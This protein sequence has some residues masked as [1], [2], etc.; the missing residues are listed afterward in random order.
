MFVVVFVFVVLLI[1]LGFIIKILIFKE[2]YE[3]YLYKLLNV[4]ILEMLVKVI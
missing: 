4:S 1:I 2:L 3:C